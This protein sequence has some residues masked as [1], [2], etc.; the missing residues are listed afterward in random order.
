MTARLRT[1]IGALAI[2]AFV[3]GCSDDQPGTVTQGCQTGA[4]CASGAC[5]F[6]VCPGY[7]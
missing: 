2:M 1:G 5:L 7:C 3:S 4:Q 6:G